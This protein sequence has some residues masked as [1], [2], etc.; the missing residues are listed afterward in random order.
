MDTHDPSGTPEAA[1]KRAISI[2]F[3]DAEVLDQAELALVEDP[4]FPIYQRGRALVRVLESPALATNRFV[5]EFAEDAP[6]IEAAPRPWVRERL[7]A[8][9]RW[10]R[11]RRTSSGVTESRVPVPARYAE[12]LLARGTWARFPVLTGIAEAPTLR[13]DGT[14]LSA[15]GYDAATGLLHRPSAV[16]PEVP[17]HPSPDD[18]R[19]AAARLLEPFDE[20]PFVAESDRAAFVGALLTRI[21]RFSIIGP[22]PM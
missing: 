6:V 22:T 1:E 2:G 21:A 19:I 14:L 12:Q 9:A 17:E 3:D 4:R 11:S 18:A 5:R 20:F 7:S 8:S 13:P 16:V 15:P 10:F